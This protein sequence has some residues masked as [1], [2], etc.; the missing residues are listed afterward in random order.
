MTAA[1]LPVD[2]IGRPWRRGGRAGKNPVHIEIDAA[3][4]DVYD[5]EVVFGVAVLDVVDGDESR[6]GVVLGEDDLVG[7]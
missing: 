3:R 6:R 5:V 2:E 7:G 1:K 4:E